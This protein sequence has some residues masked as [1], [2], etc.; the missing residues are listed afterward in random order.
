MKKVLFPLIV[1]MTVNTVGKAQESVE[2][3]NG[4]YEKK[5]VV[6]VDGAD[7]GKIYVRALEVLSD[8]AGS[9][10]KSKIGIDVQD[11]DEGMVVY[12]GR[13]EIGY[14]KANFLA[15]WEVYADFTIKIKCKDGKAQIA[16]YVPSATF[17]WSAKQ[18]PAEET[19]PI[20]ALIPKYNYKSK[21]RIK[22]A[23]IEFGPQI[24]EKFDAVIAMLASKITQKP[25]DDF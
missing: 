18:Y 25:D 6:T 10:S 11:K 7:A 14:H 21:L 15:G 2:L 8:W 22:K 5:Q 3:T 24:P 17:E 13:L 23:A 16:C 12:K 9:Q 4:A 1:F 19:V 20:S